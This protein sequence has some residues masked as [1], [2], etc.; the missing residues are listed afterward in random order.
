V[1]RLPFVISLAVAGLVDPATAHSRLTGLGNPLTPPAR[2]AAKLRVIQYTSGPQ[3]FNVGSTLIVGPTEAMLIDAEL[4]RSDAT[5]EADQIAALGKHLKAIFIT[6]PDE[7]HY[8]GAA[9]FAEK[10]PGVPIYMAP[11]GLAKY[12]TIEPARFTKIQERLKHAPPAIRDSIGREQPDSMVTPQVLPSNSLA[13]DGERVE[14][15]PDIQGDVLEPTNSFVWIPSLRTVI[16]GDIVFNKVHVWLAGSDVASRQRWHESIAR[17]DALHP[18]VVIAMHKKSL[19]TP[20]TPDVLHAMDQYLTDFDAAR[21]ASPDSAGLVT[22]MKQK[23]ED[24]AIPMLLE[25]SARVAY[26]KAPGA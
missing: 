8:T 17:I 10:F 4:N 6:H 26:A 20:D 15:V 14:I 5:R 13:V 9:A 7:D 12:K 18:Q 19:D 24:Y 11:A 22:T 2:A 3:T 16:A 21:V 23:Y 1:H 25:Y